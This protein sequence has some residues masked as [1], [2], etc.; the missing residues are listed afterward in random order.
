MN[1]SM[2]IGRTDTTIFIRL[3]DDLQ[4]DCGKCSC[5]YCVAHPDETPRWDTLAVATDKP[6]EGNDYAWTVHMPDPSVVTRGIEAGYVKGPRAT[7][8]HGGRK[9][10][11]PL[12]PSGNPSQPSPSG[13]SY[14]H[15]EDS[16]AHQDD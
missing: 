11:G 16:I 14:T 4:R 10:G 3:P 15:P 8:V 9:R 1:G 2:I 12:D 13:V 6:K 5:A 7:V